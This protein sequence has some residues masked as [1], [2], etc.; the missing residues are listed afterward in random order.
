MRA[1]QSMVVD[2]FGLLGEHTDL[3]WAK[4]RFYAS[5]RFWPE[6]LISINPH[7]ERGCLG[8]RA[9]GRWIA[10]PRHGPRLPRRRT[11]DHAFTAIRRRPSRKPPGGRASWSRPA[12]DRASR[13]ASSSRSSMRRSARAR[14]AKQ[15]RTRAIVIYPMNALANSQ[16]KELE[17]FIDQSG[18]PDRAA[19]DLRPLHRA[20]KP[21]GAGAHSARRSP[22][23]CSRTS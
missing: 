5:N 1:V 13:S 4:R 9:G 3:G 16:L 12:P 20:G 7:F 14:P 22:T 21:G 17:K 19:A 11:A 23:F 10:A 15:P 6:P 2:P 8:R 18:L